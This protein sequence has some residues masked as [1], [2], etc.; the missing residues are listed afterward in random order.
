[1]HALCSC[2]TYRASH[3]HN[4]LVVYRRRMRE[5]WRKSYWVVCIYCNGMQGPHRCSD[6]AWR[7]ALI[8]ND[9]A[10]RRLGRPLPPGVPSLS[11]ARKRREDGK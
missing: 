1:M 10:D 11:D 2:S 4:C 6:D 9:E 8:Y 5:W 7:V 3:R